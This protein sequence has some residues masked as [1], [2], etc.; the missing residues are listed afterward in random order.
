MF[1]IV[2]KRNKRRSVNE[3][4]AKG[5]SLGAP[6]WL[7]VSVGVLSVVVMIVVVIVYGG[8]EENGAE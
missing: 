7:W 5:V 8:K 4:V 3:L 1:L 6:T 2:A